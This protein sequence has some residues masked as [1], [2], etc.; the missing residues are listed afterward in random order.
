MSWNISAIYATLE[1]PGLDQTAF[2]NLIRQF[3]QSIWDEHQSTGECPE[4]FEDL[5][6]DFP[7]GNDPIPEITEQ[8][9]LYLQDLKFS[10]NGASLT[11]NAE[12][13]TDASDEGLVFDL[14]MFLFPHTQSNH[15]LVHRSAFDKQGGFANQWVGYRDPSGSVIV[16]MTT[17]Y[18]ERVF[19]DPQGI[20]V[21]LGS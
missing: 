16:E 12:Y 21:P 11:I 1:L 20:P 8:I 2:D 5:F 6:Y 14:A 4:H 15:F 19:S 7:T 3:A 18:L 9:L 13:D 10:R 17:D